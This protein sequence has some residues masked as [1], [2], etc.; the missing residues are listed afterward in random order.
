MT[1]KTRSSRELRRKVV[2]WLIQS[3]VSA[4]AKKS[5]EITKFFVGSG[6]WPLK[7]RKARPATKA[8]KISHF[9]GA[10]YSRLCSSSFLLRRRRSFRE[11]RPRLI[12]WLRL[13]KSNIVL[14]APRILGRVC[15]RTMLLVRTD[16][17]A[18][19]LVPHHVP[20]RKID[21]RNARHILQSLKC[22]NQSGAF[23]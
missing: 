17:R 1:P 11:A 8:A 15:R 6:C 20:F 16:Y 23:V 2:G 21:E 13:R 18:N 12:N 9:T 4:V 14:F 22:F 3:C 5:R 7:M 10:A 19:Q